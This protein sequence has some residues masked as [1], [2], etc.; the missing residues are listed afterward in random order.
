MILSRYTHL[1]FSCIASQCTDGD[2]RLVDGTSERNGRVE[3]CFGGVWGTVCD[4]DW[5]DRDAGV[6]CRELGF[7]DSE[8]ITNY[9]LYTVQTFILQL[10]YL[11]TGSV[12]AISQF[13][14]GEGVIFLDMIACTGN[15]AQL[16]DC[17]HS[18][19]Q[20]HDCVHI[21]DA[22]VVCQGTT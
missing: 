4:D 8:G 13:G 21:E 11:L 15:E 3:I 6:V 1:S 14:G 5:D 19:L 22:G 9:I 10:A 17:S 7:T 2:V 12:Y 16:G 18:G 20:N